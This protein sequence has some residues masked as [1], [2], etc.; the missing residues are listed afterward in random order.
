MHSCMIMESL[1]YMPHHGRY[2]VHASSLKVC[3]ACMQTVEPKGP[4]SQAGFLGTRRSLGGV[5]A[6]DSI[7]S[8][9]GNRIRNAADVDAC[10]DNCSIGDTIA[11]K[12]RRASNGVCCYL[13]DGQSCFRLCVC[14]WAYAYE[15]L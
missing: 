6:G 3:C 10:L 14:V 15:F 7:L 8:M 12:L 5:V 9:N 11:V 13:N 1:L 2:A 4:A